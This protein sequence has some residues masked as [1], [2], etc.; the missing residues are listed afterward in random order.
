MSVP[1]VR[2]ATYARISTDETNQPYS[3]GAQRDRLDA[4]VASQD[5]WHIV[6]RVE[7]R[8]S[9]K[10]QARPGLASLRAA[11]AA[12][13]IDLVLVYRV[14]RFSRNIG[15][16]GSLIEELDKVGVAFRSA[17]EPFDTSTP[18]GRMMMQMLGVFAEFERATIVERI[19][20]SMERKARLGGWTVGTYPIGYRK[21]DGVVGPAIDPASAPIVRE[22]FERY[23]QDRAGS[24]QIAAELNSRGVRTR[25]GKPW[26]RTAVL[27]VL[28]NRAYLGEV[29]FRGVWHEGHHEALI[30]RSVFD[31]AQTILEGRTAESGRRKSDGSDYLLSGLEIVCDRC[32]HRMIGAAARGRGGKRYAYYT[33]YARSRYGTSHCDQARLN[34]D[35]LEQAVL[36]QMRE[37]YSDTALIESALTEAQAEL[38]KTETARSQRLAAI[39]AEAADLRTRIE[40]YFASFEAGQLSPQ[41][42]GSRVGALQSRLQALEDERA[43]IGS[44]TPVEPVSADDVAMISWSLTEALDDVL[45]VI[46]TPRAKALLRLLIEEIRVVSPM[47]IRPTYRV[48]PMVSPVESVPAAADPV[49][50][51]EA[52]VVH[53]HLNPH[54]KRHPRLPLSGG[55]SPRP[56]LLRRHAGRT[57]ARAGGSERPGWRQATAR[58][59]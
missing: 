38:A 42:G 51:V 37:V 17:S 32:G 8:A 44:G 26:S 3:L 56:G 40:R 47:D 2:V 27:D 57:Q 28:R 41:L 23:T 39:D 14:D 19:G 34:K 52:M 43:A 35:E 50:R 5:G 6:S 55:T 11:A 21:L 33:C 15:Q 4:Y 16:L 7:D 46:P 13:S 1:D 20:A 59:A 24:A 58:Q 31:A 25:Y 36:A 29:P 48:P 30:D 54:R 53:H 18:A 49:R 22:I 12:R 45:K 9:G 10:S